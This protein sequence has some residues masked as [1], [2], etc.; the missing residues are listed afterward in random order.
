MKRKSLS[1]FFEKTGTYVHM[2][3]REQQIVNKKHSK[4]NNNGKK[5]K[6]S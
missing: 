6:T 4:T 3:P 1:D 5:E 2:T